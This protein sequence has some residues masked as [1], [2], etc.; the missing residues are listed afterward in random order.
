MPRGYDHASVPIEVGVVDGCHRLHA[1][2]FVYSECAVR[3]HITVSAVDYQRG[4]EA[5]VFPV[6]PDLEGGV[7]ESPVI[8]DLHGGNVEDL[9]FGGAS[10]QLAFVGRESRVSFVEVDVSLVDV[11]AFEFWDVDLID[12]RAVGDFARLKENGSVAVESGGHEESFAE[13]QLGPAL[14]GGYERSG[15]LRPDRAL[16]VVWV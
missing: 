2:H 13:Q 8:A 7:A 3:E 12:H 10:H 11:I 9:L 15:V 4:A 14:V 16:D 6:G 5:V 1:F